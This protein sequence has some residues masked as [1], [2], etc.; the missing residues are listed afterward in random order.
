MKPLIKVDRVRSIDEALKLESL[1]VNLIGVQLGTDDRFDDDR[2]VSEEIL[3]AI[4]SRLRRSKLFVEI[5]SKDLSTNGVSL[6]HKWGLSYAQVR[7]PEVPDLELRRGLKTLGI[8][9]IYSG[10]SVSYDD[11]PSWILSHFKRLP[12]LNAAYFQLEILPDV[13]GSWAFLKEECPRYVEDLK[14]E[15]IDQLAFTHPLIISLDFK[16]NNLIEILKRFANIRGI[17]LTVG[18]LKPG[19]YD[20][21]AL[22]F[23]ELI[24]ILKTKSSVPGV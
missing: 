6:I 3:V 15:D 11:D 22:S 16:R 23:P 24:D 5:L 21:H 2:R 7:G 12:E 14:I 9:I 19:R 1:G 10:I 20:V 13:E 17:G 18:A 4:Q 8:G